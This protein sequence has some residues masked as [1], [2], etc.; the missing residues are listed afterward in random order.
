MNLDPIEIPPFR[1]NIAPK[2]FT[3]NKKTTP[4]Y[5][6]VVTNCYGERIKDVFH[7]GIRLLENHTK[8]EEQGFY[9]VRYGMNTPG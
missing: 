9:K 5:A 8:L 3:L 4:L 1:G 7:T 2:F 6:Y